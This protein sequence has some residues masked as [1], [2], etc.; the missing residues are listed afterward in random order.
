MK[1]NVNEYEFKRWFETNRPNNF[2]RAG[3][4]ALFED[5]EQYEEDTGHELEFDPIALCC[6]YTEYENLDEFKS[7]YTCKEYQDIVD[8]DGLHDYTHTI[9]VGKDSFIIQNF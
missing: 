4:Q 5:L 3:L 6:E 8:I 9:P 1:T 7:N 2:S